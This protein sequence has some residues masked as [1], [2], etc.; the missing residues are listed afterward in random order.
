MAPFDTKYAED[1]L[2]LWGDFDVIKYTYTPHLTTIDECKNYIEYRIKKT[3]KEFTDSFVILQSGKA[4]GMIG[5][6]VVDAE[7]QVFGFYYQLTKENWGRGFAIEAASA[8]KNY[9]VN[10]YPNAI[11]KAE[12]VSVNLASINVLQKI[13]LRPIHTQKNGFQRNGLVLDI[14]EFSNV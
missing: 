1:L 12:A 4:I 7:T 3:N 5:C 11:I 2:K 13:G 9:L 6:P 8:V 10:K 14:I